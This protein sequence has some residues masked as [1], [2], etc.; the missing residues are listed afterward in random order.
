[1]PRPMGL[2]KEGCARGSSIHHVDME[3]EGVSQMT[4][5]LHKLYLVKWTTKGEGSKIS[6]KLSTWVM[7]S[8]SRDYTAKATVTR[9]VLWAAIPV[10][11]GRKV[12]FQN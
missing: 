9:L 11:I 12:H 8:P 4:I 2:K 6:K 3:G 10:D 7:D 1:M 5:L